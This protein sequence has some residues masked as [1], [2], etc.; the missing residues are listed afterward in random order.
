M[1]SP[2]EKTLAYFVYRHRDQRIMTKELKT[3]LEAQK[4]A[5]ALNSAYKDLFRIGR[6]VDLEGQRVKKFDLF[7][8]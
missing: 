5:G 3:K 8:K 2:N 4:A 7:S 1:I 6:I